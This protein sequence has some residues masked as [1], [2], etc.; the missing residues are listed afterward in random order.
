ME[1]NGDDAGALC[2]DGDYGEVSGGLRLMAIA[3]E[4]YSCPQWDAVALEGTMRNV[5]AG[6]SGGAWGRSM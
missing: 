4:A 1:R 5:N 6:S 2:G 3:L